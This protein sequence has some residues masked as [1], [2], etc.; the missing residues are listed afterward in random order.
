MS[1]Q[2]VLALGAAPL[3]LVLN[4]VIVA[5]GYFDVAE[6]S[7]RLLGPLKCSKIILNNQF[8]SL[9]FNE[10]YINTID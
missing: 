2:H 7:L 5:G 3:E 6:R 1:T 4:L 9:M 8:S 10:N